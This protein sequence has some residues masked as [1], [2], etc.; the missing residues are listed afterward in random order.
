MFL[1]EVMAEKDD[2][3]TP[4][5]A[6]E[7]IWYFLHGVSRRKPASVKTIYKVE[8]EGVDQPVVFRHERELDRWWFEVKSLSGEVIEIACSKEEYQQAA[9]NEIPD[10]WLRFVQKLDSLSK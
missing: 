3:I 5:L 8:V 6:A 4:A 9:T 2:A 1:F 10:R 7:I